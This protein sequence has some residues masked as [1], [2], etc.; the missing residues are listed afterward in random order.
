MDKVY[1][2]YASDYVDSDNPTITVVISGED[3]ATVT[4]EFYLDVPGDELEEFVAKLEAACKE[5]ALR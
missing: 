1:V 3:L 5:H 2:E 4:V